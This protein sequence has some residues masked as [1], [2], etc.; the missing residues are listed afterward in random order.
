[1]EKTI[2]LA[3]AS[4]QKQFSA[5][6]CKLVEKYAEILASEGLLTTA[7]E[8]LKIL[9]SDELSAEIVV[10]KDRIAFSTESGMFCFWLSFR[11]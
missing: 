1:M 9:G 6:F 8:Y 11:C 5:S 3:L 10:L 4:G 7:M 2:V